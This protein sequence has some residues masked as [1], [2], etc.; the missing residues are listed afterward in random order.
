MSMD[1]KFE[2]FGVDKTDSFSGCIEIVQKSIGSVLKI[3]GSI[4]HLNPLNKSVLSRVYVFFGMDPL[5]ES[6]VSSKIMD[7]LMFG[8]AVSTEKWIRLMNP[9]CPFK[10]RDP[11]QI[12]VNGS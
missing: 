5:N 1:P 2:I 4:Y 7:P 3:D 11:L 9:F 12:Y 10:I 8:S 6:V